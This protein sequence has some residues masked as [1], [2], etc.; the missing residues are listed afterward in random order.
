MQDLYHQ[1]YDAGA[2]VMSKALQALEQV[3]VEYTPKP[4]KP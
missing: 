2:W 3:V 4:Y 1:Q